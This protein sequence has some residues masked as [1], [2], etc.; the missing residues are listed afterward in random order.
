[1]SRRPPC[2]NE[3]AHADAPESYAA[4]FAW[5]ERKAR[6]H[7]QVRCE[8]CGRFSVWVPRFDPEAEAD[9]CQVCRS[10]KATK[11]AGNYQVCDDCYDDCS[12][13]VEDA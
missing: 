11:T 10:D 4:W 1:M 3:A 9:P 8:G 2:P 5:A 7:T 6:T 13:A 12:A